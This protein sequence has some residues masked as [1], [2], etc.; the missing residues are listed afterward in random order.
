MIKQKTKQLWVTTPGAQGSECL[1]PV[2][3][4]FAVDMHH[5]W[6]HC[7]L[8]SR[9]WLLQKMT[10]FVT[11]PHCWHQTPD[12]SNLRKEG[13]ILTQFPGTVCCREV[14]WWQEQEAAGHVTPIVRKQRDECWDP[15]CFRPFVRSWSL[16]QLAPKVLATRIIGDPSRFVLSFPETPFQADPVVCFPS[17][18]KS[19]WP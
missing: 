1:V 15:A 12:K 6:Y 8:L 18:S 4:T 17:N 13:I 3:R 16:V 10:I 2:H 19:S 11:L 14:S 9:T 7:I 5:E